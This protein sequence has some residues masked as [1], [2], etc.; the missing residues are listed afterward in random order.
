MSSLIE[1]KA[2]RV[3][4]GIPFIMCRA[5]MVAQAGPGT[6]AVA[7][8]SLPAIYEW[9]QES[10]P[11][12][13]EMRAF[14]DAE[15]RL[16]KE[17]NL[18]IVVSKQ[19]RSVIQHYLPHAPVHIVSNIMPAK[20]PPGFPCA[21]RQGL[22][23][24]GSLGHPP[25]RGAIED[26]FEHVL[27][28]LHKI[29]PALTKDPGFRVHIVG[30]GNGARAQ[31]Q[32]EKHKNIS[33][34]HVNLSSEL[35]ELLLARVRVFVA[36]LLVGGGVKGKVMQ[37]M[38]NGLPVVSYEVG[39]EGIDVKHGQHAMV[40]HDAAEFADH[41]AKLHEDCSAWSQVSRGGLRLIR[42]AYLE[43][44]ARLGLKGV[45]DELAV[46]KPDP[47]QRKCKAGQQVT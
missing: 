25:N 11:E 46:Q 34:L 32:V 9:L 33:V 13:A 22:L 39:V 45:L 20:A 47:R 1:I 15:L 18:T 6:S 41:I 36:P 16:V 4:A 17:T 43:T 24:V 40:A 27:P 12:S 37:A 19:E 29:A 10:R 28:A 21:Q 5:R 31:A 38:A 44:N 23:F 3:H 8:T 30:S 7:N 2:P 26:L 42:E 35:L 14:R